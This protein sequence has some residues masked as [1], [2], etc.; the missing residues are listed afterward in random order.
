MPPMPRHQD[1]IVKRRFTVS[2]ALATLAAT[3][4]LVWVPVA[5]AQACNANTALTQPR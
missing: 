3:A 2:F 1:P 4:L 5:Q